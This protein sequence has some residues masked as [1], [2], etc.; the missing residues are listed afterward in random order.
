MCQSKEEGGYRC[1][2]SKQLIDSLK[3]TEEIYSSVQAIGTPWL[4]NTEP[5]PTIEDIKEAVKILNREI[6]RYD[7]M[8]QLENGVMHLGNMISRHSDAKVHNFDARLKAAQNSAIAYKEAFRLEPEGSSKVIEFNHQVTNEN[9]AL[10]AEVRQNLR[11][12]LSQ[13]RDFDREL[14]VRI[15]GREDLTALVRSAS[16]VYPEQWN[17][18]LTQKLRTKLVDGKES[19]FDPAGNILRIRKGDDGLFRY[20]SLEE[21]QAAKNT[22]PLDYSTYHEIVHEMAHKYEGLYSYVRKM[23][24]QFI[25]R[26]CIKGS[27]GKALVTNATKDSA[28]IR[29]HFSNPYTG[30]AYDDG[31]NEVFSTGVE[32][33]LFGTS[34]S[35][36]GLALPSKEGSLLLTQYRADIEH[37]NLTLGILAGIDLPYFNDP[38]PEMFPEFNKIIRRVIKPKG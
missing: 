2:P 13:V 12:T 29:D 35:L 37:R 26:R 9:L 7:N 22:R 11:E 6:P 4:S 21:A 10:G 15:K 36:I 8:T 18:V 3:G 31:G 28:W 17:G 27:D 34:G 1:M 5:V 32:S 30:K 20:G 19:S 33:T 38:K 14:P 23:G 16:K 24:N 25:A